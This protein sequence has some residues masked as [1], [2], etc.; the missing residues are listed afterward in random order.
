MINFFNCPESS[1]AIKSMNKLFNFIQKKTAHKSLKMHLI[2]GFRELFFPNF[3]FYSYIWKHL[4]NGCAMFTIMLL[5]K[6]IENISRHGF[7]IFRRGWIPRLEIKWQFYGITWYLLSFQSKSKSTRSNFH[8]VAL[9][10]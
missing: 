4:R 7:M 8:W 6:K 1:Y 5:D 3:K 10:F 9:E 2:C